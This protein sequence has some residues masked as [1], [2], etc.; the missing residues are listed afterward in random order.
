[1]TATASPL[2][3]RGLN[4]R[5]AETVEKLL[6]AGL[7]M[8]ERAAYDDL[9][10]RLIASRAGVSAATA[11]TYFSSKD[12][13]FAALFWRHISDAESPRLRGGP[14]ARMRACVRHLCGLVSESPALAA[15]ASKSLLGSDPDVEELRILMGR[16]WSDVFMNA[17][18]DAAEPALVR[19]LLF[20]FSGALLEAGMGI[21][22]YDDL[23]DQVEASFAVIL[24]GNV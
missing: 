3:R 10:I 7:A 24:R 9:T 11:Y 14:E 20:C 17:L 5:Q 18:G 6:D 16:H 8:L 12:H 15:A 4:A 22:A 21:F 13:L 19:A 2:P 23:A 1:M